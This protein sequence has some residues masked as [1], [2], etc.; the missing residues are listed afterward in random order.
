[1]SP[2]SIPVGMY[3]HVNHHAN[4]FLTVSVENF[5]RQ[6]EW[7]RREGYE[8]LDAE[9]FL[10]ILRGERRPV[11]RSFVLT[12]D[13][14]WLDLYVHAFPIL[15][16][17][18]HKFIVFTV[19]DWTEQASQP[20][21]SPATLP[22]IPTHREAEK[23]VKEDRAG[24]VIC[25]W[26]QLR[27]M[28][29]SGLASIESHTATHLHSTRA[30][31]EILAE[32]FRRCRAAIQKNLDR[33]SR[34]LCWPYGDHNVQCLKIAREAGFA[35]TYLV[36]RGINL[37]GGGT[38][39]VKRFTVDDRDENWLKKQLEIFSSPITGYLYARLKPDRWFRQRG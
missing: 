38:F 13:D 23:L 36:R 26:G 16:E 2:H 17:F 21:I 12:F 20:A 19:S 7:L 24:D 15:K 31:P 14:A 33:D 10:K 32:E 35:T 8:T 18:G 5:R 29:A 1:M 6:M 22:E 28:Q 25:N 37:A 34:Q 9:T 27:E 4:D 3:H 39:A 30:T 11:L